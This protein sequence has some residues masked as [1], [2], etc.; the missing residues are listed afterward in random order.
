MHYK[1]SISLFTFLPYKQDDISV[2]MCLMSNMC[3]RVIK[4]LANMKRKKKE[5]TPRSIHFY[6]N[7]FRNINDAAAKAMNPA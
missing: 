3:V 1:W 4:Q 2:Y 5:K 7:A 6:S